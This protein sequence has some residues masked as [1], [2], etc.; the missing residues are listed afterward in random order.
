MFKIAVVIFRECLEIAILLGIILAVTS[1]IKNSRFYIILGSIIGIAS[2]S[3]IAFFAKYI[4]VS[5][6]GLG[7]ETLSIIVIFLTVG[8]IC[9]TV[10]WMKGQAA[11]I[12][13]D[14]GDLSDQI[15]AG[16]ESYLMLIMVVAT[17][18][19]REGTEIILFVYSIA[20]SDNLEPDNYLLGLGI[21]GLCGIIVGTLIYLGL[22]NF[23]GKYIFKVSS[24][25]LIL[26]AAGLSAQAA[27]IL[28][29]TGMVM[30]LSDELWNSSWLIADNS[31]LGKMLSAVIGYI[32]RPTE[33]QGVLYFGTILIIVALLQI[34]KS[35]STLK[36]DK[37]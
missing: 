27:G 33:L 22:V 10:V 31:F 2:A 16:K 34:K 35:T 11:R 14:L 12:K 4:S 13:S 23:A 37:N 3:V 17:S 18:I 32:A 19:F 1:N 15:T 25:L 9:W 28:N 30:A 26:I 7:D 29:S 24:L 6:S 8:I 20:S 21:G 36:K 5:L